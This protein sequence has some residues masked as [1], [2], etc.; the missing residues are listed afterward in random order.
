MTGVVRG[1]IFSHFVVVYDYVVDPIPV[2]ADVRA[3][4][5]GD[6]WRH[7]YIM[8]FLSACG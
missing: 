1:H 6:G 3:A 2:H 4:V 7:G 8:P 5:D